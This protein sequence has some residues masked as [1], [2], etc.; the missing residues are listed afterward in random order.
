M[1][2]NLSATESKLNNIGP[3]KG[4]QSSSSG[5]SSDYS[6]SGPGGEPS[7]S[8]STVDS[9]T[10]GMQTTKVPAARSPLD[11][12]REMGHNPKNV[13]QKVVSFVGAPR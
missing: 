5:M 7:S 8:S 12:R 3:S 11:Q 13:Q 1:N 9:V 2:K 10:R 4:S 6:H